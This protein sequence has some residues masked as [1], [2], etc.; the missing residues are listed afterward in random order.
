MEQKNLV[1]AIAL[2]IAVLFLYSM[3]FAPKPQ[4]VSQKEVVQTDTQQV[5]QEGQEKTTEAAPG[6][7]SRDA[8]DILF[9][10]REVEKKTEEPPVPVELDVKGSEARDITIETDLFSAVFTTRGAGLKS[11]V[12]KKYK[13]DKKN[14]LDL[15]AQKVKDFNIFPFYISTESDMRFKEVNEGL[16]V[17]DGDP[18]VE[19][20]A[21][22]KQ[23]VTFRYSDVMKKISVTKT[24]EFVDNSYI[25]D[26]KC[27]I[28]KDGKVVPAP[29]VFGPDLENNILE[30]RTGSKLRIWAFDGDSADD[31]IFE[32]LKTQRTEDGSK[33]S[34]AQGFLDGSYYWVAYDRAYFTVM[35]KREQNA[36]PIKYSVIKERK[37]L[38]ATEKGKKAKKVDE[39][40]SYIVVMDPVKVFLGPKDEEVLTSVESTFIGATEIVDYGWFGPIAKIMLKGITFIQKYIPNYGWAL[41]I[42]TFFLKVLLFPLTYTSSV[43]MA[44]MQTLQ[45]KIKAI[46][47]K[48][49][50]LRDPEQRKQMNVETMELYKK[51][52]VNPA[53]GCLPML[54]QFPI[55]LGVFALL[56]TSISVRHEPWIIWIQDLSLKDP[57][58]L[59]PI[60]MGL[61][62]LVVQKMTPTS[63]EGPQAKM[64]FLMPIVFTFVVLGLPSGLTLYWFISNLLQVG[65]QYIINK[66]IYS[67]KREEDKLKKQHKRKKGVS[68]R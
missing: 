60:L 9:G 28:I 30:E 53:G 58:Y 42:F 8:A 63:A 4:P 17:Y 45:P 61:S 6:K 51:E 10:N 57:I 13:D 11:F 3:F 31:K 18:V 68:K 37:I 32:S 54:L 29:V 49:K 7:S 44:K 39:L 52:K 46:K 36:S 67:E 1:V 47:K 25:V 19:V 65:Q 59:L 33:L 55:L 16:F 14:P 40:Y 20:E 26:M 5:K 38:P 56:R 62:Q 64:M 34:T 23:S 22:G 24:F 48:Y 43:S 27:R 66:K 12:L 15:V 41:V 50:N 21:G 2:S 35:F